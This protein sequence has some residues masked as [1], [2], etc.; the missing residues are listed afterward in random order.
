MQSSRRGHVAGT[1][2]TMLVL[3]TYIHTY[4]LSTTRNN[5][6]KKKKKAVLSQVTSKPTGTWKLAIKIFQKLSEFLG[7]KNVLHE[8]HY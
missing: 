2:Q 1:E 5:N 8:G 7:H 6:I 3:H 4:S